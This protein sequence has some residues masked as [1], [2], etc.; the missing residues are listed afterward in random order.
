MGCRKLEIV[1]QIEARR[2]RN[3]EVPLRKKPTRFLGEYCLHQ[4]RS[5]SEINSKPTRIYESVEA[6]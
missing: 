2:R 6:D 5:W 4:E 3:K 1:A